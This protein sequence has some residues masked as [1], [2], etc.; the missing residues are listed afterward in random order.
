MN[1][2]I[3]PGDYVR[4]KNL[5]VSGGCDIYVLEVSADKLSVRCCYLLGTEQIDK[6]GWL[7][8]SD[9]Q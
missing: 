8:V 2:E 9:L 5:L 1:K 7:M 6:T 4:H 3:K